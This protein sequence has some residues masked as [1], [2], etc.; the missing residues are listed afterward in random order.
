MDQRVWGGNTVWVAQ[1]REEMIGFTTDHDREVRQQLRGREATQGD[2]TEAGSRWQGSESL[3][4]ACYSCA[5]AAT[6]LALI[7]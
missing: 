4:P 1:Q 7:A 2:E 6:L 3:R 5:V